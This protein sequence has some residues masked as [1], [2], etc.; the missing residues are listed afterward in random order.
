MVVTTLL[1]FIVVTRKWRW[2]RLLAVA[3]VGP[4]LLLD[5]VFLGANALKLLSGGFVPLAIGAVLVFVMLTWWL[6]SRLIHRKSAADLPELAQAAGSLAR[7]CS[8]RAAGVA[9]FLSADPDRVPGALLHNLKHN[10]VLHERNLIV[11]VRTAADPRVAEADRGQVRRISDDFVGVT[12]TYG[13]MET[14]N[15]PRALA[16]LKPCGI[17]TDPM[18]TSYFI[19]RRTIV[20]ARRSL[21]PRGMDSLYIWLNRNAADPMD[22]FQIPPGRVVE[23]GTQVSV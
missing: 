14:P 6:G 5:T 13:F 11:S 23:L 16:R 15:I 17:A 10:R 3:V 12:L 18:N 2:P 4:M 7:R 21:L 19:G 1:A 20:H 22:F 8:H 9:V